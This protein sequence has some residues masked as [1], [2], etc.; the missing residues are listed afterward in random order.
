[1]FTPLELEKIEFNTAFMGGYKKQDVEEVFNELTADYETLYKENISNKD[2]LSMLQGLVD[3][4]KTMEDSLQN[5]LLLAQTSSD[6]AIRAAQDKAQNIVKEAEAKAAY[7]L[8]EAEEKV[9][10]LAQQELDMKRNIGVFAARNVSQLRTQIEILNGMVSGTT[11]PAPAFGTATD[12]N[13][14]APTPVTPVAK[15]PVPAPSPMEDT[16][17]AGYGAQ[18]VAA[19]ETE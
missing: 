2:K 16:Q 15:E 6:A 8:K 1:M 3:K 13:A 5:A 9:K 11:E 10:A 17:I 18:P 7:I 19:N 12:A 14:A 4:Y